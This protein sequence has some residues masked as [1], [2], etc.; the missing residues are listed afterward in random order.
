VGKNEL[1]DASAKNIA[2]DQIRQF[3]RSAK[4]NLN[5]I[6]FVSTLQQ[7]QLDQTQIPERCEQ[8]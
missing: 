5:P 3:G 8:T 7:K 1:W 6:D 4:S 2:G